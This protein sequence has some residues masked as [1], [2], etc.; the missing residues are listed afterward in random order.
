MYL[1]NKCF[2]LLYLWNDKNELWVTGEFYQYIKMQWRNEKYRQCWQ[3][4]IV[5]CYMCNYSLERNSVYGRGP[6]DTERGKQTEIG[7][8]R[9]CRSVVKIKLYHFDTEGSRSDHHCNMCPL[10]P[11]RNASLSDPSGPCVQLWQET[12]RRLWRGISSPGQPRRRCIISE[13]CEAQRLF[14]DT[15]RDLL[16]LWNRLSHTGPTH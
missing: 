5:F 8:E 9:G 6:I 16:I 4:I 10:R 3:N 2:A 7:R 14:R 1:N 11:Q 15:C 12:V 13:V